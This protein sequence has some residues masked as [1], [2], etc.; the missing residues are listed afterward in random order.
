MKT[1][2][3]RNYEEIAELRAQLAAL[4]QPKEAG[5]GK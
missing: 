4:L 2:D 5:D 1:I 3:D